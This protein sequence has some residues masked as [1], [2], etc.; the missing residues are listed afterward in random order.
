MLATA[1]DPDIPEQKKMCGVRLATGADIA[2]ADS[3]NGYP[4]GDR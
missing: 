1:P 4:T 2:A 3:N